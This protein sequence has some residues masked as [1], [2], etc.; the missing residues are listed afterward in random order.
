MGMGWPITPVAA[1]RTRCAGIRRCS[2]T[3]LVISRASRIPCSP[4]HTLEQPEEATMAWTWRPL[5]CSWDTSTGAP[6]TWFVVKT[7]AARAG[8]EE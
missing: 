6:L 3:I 7:A 4:V 8:D 5:T 1:M 2:P